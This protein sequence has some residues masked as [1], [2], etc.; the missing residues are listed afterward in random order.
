MKVRPPIHLA[1]RTNC[2]P[3]EQE[4]SKDNMAAAYQDLLLCL[5]M[6]PFALA[7]MYA[8]SHKDYE[9]S[10]NLAR[11][12]LRDAI[13]DA[14]GVRDIIQDS[15]HTFKGTAFRSYADINPENE[16]DLEDG[17]QDFVL[18]KNRSRHVHRKLRKMN[19]SHSQDINLVEDRQELEFSDLGDEE[20]IAYRDSRKLTFGDYR[21]PSIVDMKTEMEIQ[22]RNRRKL[23]GKD[24]SDAGRSSDDG[25]EDEEK[26]PGSVGS[27]EGLLG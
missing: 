8:F 11:L 3:A 18:D 21:F 15:Y 14:F 22:E 10:Q 24:T 23:A 9:T 20:E 6:L 19:R 12:P 26:S 17:V 13:R 4:Y 5:E 1:N 16:R 7:H 2:P 25:D 27:N